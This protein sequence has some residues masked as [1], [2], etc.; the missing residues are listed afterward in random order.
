M[1][2]R[3]LILCDEKRAFIYTSFFSF[4]ISC[5]SS[6]WTVCF[7]KYCLCC[8]K[9]KH[10]LGVIFRP[11]MNPSVFPAAWY[12]P[13][14]SGSNHDVPV[15]WEEDWENSKVAAGMLVH[16]FTHKYLEG[17]VLAASNCGFWECGVLYSLQQTLTLITKI[18]QFSLLKNVN[19][20]RRRGKKNS[21]SEFSNR[22]QICQQV[23]PRM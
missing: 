7:L 23:G 2:S 13:L 6:S 5:Y 4:P 17:A 15:W 12:R 14:G 22:K 8:A 1:A 9:P 20:S 3:F 10:H 21:W 16:L 11:G 18:V 19:N